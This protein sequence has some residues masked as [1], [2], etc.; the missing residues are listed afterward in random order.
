[1]TTRILAVALLL[2]LAA[3][4]LAAQE[5]SP[6]AASTVAP[7]EPDMIL[8]RVILSIED[9]SVEQVRAQLPPPED[10]LPPVTRIPVMS[11]GDLPIGE[12]TIPAAAVQTEAVAG[13]PKDRGLTS[14]VTLGAGNDNRLVANISLKTLGQDPRLALLFN[15]ETLDGFSGKPAG[16]GFNLRNDDLDGSLS[17]R[18]G[19][20]DT[21]LKGSFL[22]NETGLQGQ[23]LPSYTARLGRS[24]FSSAFFSGSPADWLTLRG[25]AD[26]G[27]DTLILQGVT[28][29]ERDGVRVS[30]SFSAD[31]HFGA[32]KLGL[33]TRYTFRSDPAGFGGQLH[34]FLGSG[35]FSL[36]LPA[37]FLVEGSVGWFGNS[38]G[39]SL[40][41]FSLSLTG[42]PIQLL[43]LSVSGGYRV[44]PY[45]MHDQ[46]VVHP[47]ILPTG[48]PDDRGW[49]G[50]TTVQ[51][52]FTT[53][54]AASVKASFMAHEAMPVGSIIEDPATGLFPM[55]SQAGREFST[56]AGLRW[57]IS[58]SF[59]LSGGWTHQYLDRPFYVPLD[60]LKGELVG[61]EPSG[62]FGGSVSL[63]FA[64]T[65]SGEIQQPLL[66][67]SG[68][69]KISDAVKLHLD[70][71]DLLWPFIGGSRWDIPPYVTP[72]FRVLGSLSVTL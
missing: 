23:A 21:V 51:L 71:E 8:P 20:V 44:T 67:L 57:V 3:L 59:S 12:P 56:D 26:A 70:A 46:L 53:D 62:R 31:A 11:E 54:L 4:G 64:P 52:N 72:G 55:G 36:D 9:L 7:G 5:Q 37:T 16:S 40:V 66:G 17:F 25:G 24:L 49:F 30:P 47:L 34:R 32:L 14:E 29:L 1:M 69:W 13:P 19:A 61:L 41:P 22:E 28:P 48:I 2:P 38:A 68:F 6:A 15:H 35:S 65:V 60:S 18:M 42:T 27:D 33:L 58:P 43:T 50:D 10:L 45:D 39:L 63:L